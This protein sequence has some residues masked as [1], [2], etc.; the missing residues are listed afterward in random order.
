MNKE[1]ILK[2]ILTLTKE[3]EKQLLMSNE[4]NR[5]YSIALGEK[6]EK[7]VARG[8]ASTI[9]TTIAEGVNEVATHKYFADNAR[10]RAKVIVY[11]IN[12]LLAVLG[13]NE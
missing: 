10:A 6:V 3:L 9:S 2:E 7:L 12:A 4:Y 13:S 8:T 5:N 1:T 11:E